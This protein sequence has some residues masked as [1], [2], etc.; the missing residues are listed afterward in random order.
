VTLNEVNE[1]LTLIQKEADEE[2][3]IIFGVVVDDALGEELRVTVIATG[4]GSGEETA[5]QHLGQVSP[6]SLS[7]VEEQEVPTFIRRKKGQELPKVAAAGGKIEDF[8]DFEEDRFDL[9][10]F[11]RKQAD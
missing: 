8:S 9:P 7:V 2:A 3:N 11:M 5:I 10:T 6:I 4:F 1:A